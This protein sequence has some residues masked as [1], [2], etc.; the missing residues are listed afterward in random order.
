MLSGPIRILALCTL[1]LTLSMSTALA[2]TDVVVTIKPIHALISGVMKDIG[3]P[4]LLIKG[5]QSPHS[6]SLRP[7]D[8]RALADA[9]LVV[10]IG[11]ELESFLV[12][13]LHSL[14]P[15]AQKVELLRKPE[16]IRLPQ[17]RGGN[18][19][20]GH[21]HSEH[22]DHHDHADTVDTEI[23]RSNNPHLW[24]DP[25]NAIDI[26]TLTTESLSELDPNNAAT[27]RTNAHHL[28]QRLTALDRELAAQLKPLQ[29]RPYLV[30][31]DAYPYLEARYRLNPVGAISINPD[32]RTGAKRVAEIRATI[33]SSGA[34]CLFSEPQFRPQLVNALLDGTD[35]RGGELDPLGADLPAGADSYFELMRALATAL[36]GCL[37]PS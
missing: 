35:A 25:H 27:Y 9:E 16:L 2:A 37:D 6:Y 15:S 3:K 33:E 22:P 4:T 20:D 8:A 29:S 26:V 30:F 21:D 32:R 23:R 14:A 13:P 31:H 24:L 7:S 36:E 19:T 11:P 18:W 1:L 12:Q 34:L 10:W 5:G 17:R 28:I